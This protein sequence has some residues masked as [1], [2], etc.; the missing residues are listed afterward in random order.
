MSLGINGGDRPLG[1]CQGRHDGCAR[2]QGQNLTMQFH[3]CSTLKWIMRC[4]RSCNCRLQSL[5]VDSVSIP[6]L[7]DYG[8]R[9]AVEIEVATRNGS[10][11]PHTKAVQSPLFTGPRDKGRR[12]DRP[13][14]V[15]SH[16]SR[17][18]STSMFSAEKCWR[19]ESLDG[20][21]P[22]EQKLLLD[23]AASIRAFL[24]SILDSAAAGVAE[25]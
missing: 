6:M 12:R 8:S 17:C 3:L 10:V 4:R 24:Y 7:E 19:A 13:A 5:I 21:T 16:T 20:L 11:V 22:L 2:E 14:P 9:E 1:H 18:V 15:R 25:M 23:S